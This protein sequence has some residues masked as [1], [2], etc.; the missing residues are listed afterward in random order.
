MKT[1][2]VSKLIVVL[3]LGL[4]T[5]SLFANTLSVPVDKPAYTVDI[6]A[7]WK[8]KTDKADKS[9]EATEPNSHVY[10][11][12]WVVDKSDLS[13]LTGDLEALLKDSMKSIDEKSSEE[14]IEN[15][16][17]KFHVLR[18][19]GVDKR[20]GGKV[21]FFVAVFQAGPGKAGI[22]Y[23]DWDSDAPADVTKTINTIMNSIKLAK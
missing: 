18:G 21:K 2:T 3:C 4:A 20:E 12:G 15:N 5:A 23:A 11:A 10:M 17:I 6:P 14:A 1:K 22:Y 19:S 8:P 16:G 9:V 13:D 7:D